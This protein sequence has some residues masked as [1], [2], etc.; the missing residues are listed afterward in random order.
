M[1]GLKMKPAARNA[2]FLGM[3]CSAAYLAVYITRNTLGAVSPQ[4]IQDGVLATEQVGSL[5]T[6]YFITYAVGQLINGMIGDRIKA[7][8]MICAGLAFA[9][10]SG[11]VF[12][13]SASVPVLALYIAYGMSGFFLSMIYGPMTKVVS[14]STELIYATRCSLGYTFASFLG[15]P[16]AGFLAFALAWQTVFAVSAGSLIV[17]AVLCFALF[18]IMEKRGIVKYSE[19]RRQRMQRGGVR[20]L[21]RH[22]IVKFTLVSMLTG[23]VRTSVV[24]WLPTYISQRLGFEPNTA[25]LI[26]TVATFVISTATFVAVFLYECL[27]R[28]IHLTL[29]LSFASSAVCFLAVYFVRQPTANIIFMVAAILSSN[30]AAA[31]LWSVYCPSLR[32]TGMVS[33]ATGFL[34]F[35]S[36]IA[37][38]I[39]SSVFAGAVSDIGWDGLV[40]VWLGLMVLGVI[41]ALPYKRREA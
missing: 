25:A 8:Y 13:F 17:M 3:T 27:H 14:E 41:V 29:L 20:I 6:I 18:G 31:M 39:S 34:D 36:Y 11:V 37:A 28:N 15:S 33:S 7:K 24:F 38:A 10:I 4:M 19:Y 40:L 2:V 26:F 22:Q 23:I 12:S 30:C 16:A 9:G 35:V 32:E 5:S 1:A 21:I